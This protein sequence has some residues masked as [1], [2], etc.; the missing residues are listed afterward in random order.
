MK[1]GRKRQFIR[2]ESSS[3][4]GSGIIKMSSMVLAQESHNPL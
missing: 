3:E 2:E 4:N 1:S